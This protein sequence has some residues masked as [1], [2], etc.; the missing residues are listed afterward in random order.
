MKEKASK[1]QVRFTTG[2]TEED[3]DPVGPL[4]IT[5]PTNIYHLGT[6]SW[7]W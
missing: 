5:M 6:P 3:G 1:K 7:L 4:R 2:E